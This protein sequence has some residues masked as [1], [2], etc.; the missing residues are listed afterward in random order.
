MQKSKTA[1]LIL[2]IFLG[3]WGAHRLYVG[4]TS[5]GIVQLLTC[6]G[7]GIWTVIDLFSILTDNFTDAE[8]NPLI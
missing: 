8:G 6:G 7:C 1:T 4:K 5:S 2:C 3:G